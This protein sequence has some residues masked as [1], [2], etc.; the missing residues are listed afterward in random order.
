MSRIR[1]VRPWPV[2][3]GLSDLAPGTK[4]QF[5]VAIAAPRKLGTYKLGVQLAMTAPHRSRVSMAQIIGEVQVVPNTTP[6][7]PRKDGK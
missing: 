1:S 3:I 2:L 6:G 4:R 7:F 5:T